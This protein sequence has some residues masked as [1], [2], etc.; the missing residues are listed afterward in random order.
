VA[1]EWHCDRPVSDTKVWVKQRCVIEFL[2]AEKMAPIDIHWCL[3]NINGDQIVDVSTVRL[4]VVTVTWKKGHVLDGHAQLSWNEEHLSQ[5]IHANQQMVVTVE[6]VFCSWEFALSNSVI[7]LFVSV[8]VS[9]EI[10]RRHYFQDNLHMMFPGFSC[11]DLGSNLPFQWQTFWAF[12][13]ISICF[14]TT[15][16]GF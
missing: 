10:N 1:A 12:C 3:L 8:E 2:Y 15:W 14:V 6:R 4:W 9:M 16:Y 7:V 5:I 11:E 13:C